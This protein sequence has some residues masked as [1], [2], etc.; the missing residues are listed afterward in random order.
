[1]FAVYFD[2]LG[3]WNPQLLRELKGRLNLR[4]LAIAISLSLFGQLLLFLFQLG[5]L[6]SIHKFVNVQNV[7][8]TGSRNYPYSAPNCLIGADRSFLINWPL[9]WQDLFILI[10]IASLCILLVSGSYLI[11][12]DLSKEE[13]LG[14]LNFIRLS[15]QSAETILW[16]KLLGVPVLFYLMLLLTIPLSIYAGLAAGLSPIILICYY[17]IVAGSCLFFFSLSLLFGLV[18]TWLGSLQAWLGS[19]TLSMA[20]FSYTLMNTGGA[21]INNFAAWPRILFPTT[22]IPGIESSGMLPYG[23]NFQLSDLTWFYLPIGLTTIGITL[24]TLVL[25]GIGT[26]WVWRVLRRRFR[27]VNTTILTK[28]QSYALTA[29]LQL[30]MLGFILQE[31]IEANRYRTE[32]A[33]IYMLILNLILGLFLIAAL[34]PQ[35]SSLIEWA[36]Y[37][38]IRRSD[39]PAWLRQWLKEFIWGEKSPAFLAIA[40]NVMIFAIVQLPWIG[41]TFA[42]DAPKTQGAALLGTAFALSILLIYAAIVQLCLLSASPRR[43]VWAAS[44]IVLAITMPPII[45]GFLGILPSSY[46]GAPFW[47]FTAFPWVAAENILGG[48]L[49]FAGLSHG[50]AIVLLN[51]QFTRQLSRLGESASKAL[52]TPTPVGK[53]LAR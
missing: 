48:T 47:L 14:T 23:N 18:T 4:N 20:L 28:A 37:R 31:S 1:M 5:R 17:S 19:G 25:Y 44:L 40:V 46:A 34:T 41:F 6:P 30:I 39:R 49:G 51:L 13:R 11:I 29:I 22:L 2:R 12:H 42:T 43:T 9:W 15:P 27:A 16:G 21:E 50:L 45:L 52:L 24:F 38:Y 10:S 53:P 8:C 32:M 36:R 33:W 26:I 3:N 35:R 7:Y